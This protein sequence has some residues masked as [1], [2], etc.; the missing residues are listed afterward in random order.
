MDDEIQTIR[1]DDLVD[2][3]FVLR[4]VDQTGVEYVEL[5]DSLKKRGFLNSICVRPCKRWLG[6]WEIVDGRWRVTAAR[7]VRILTVPCIVKYGLTDKDVLAMQVIANAARPKTAPSAYARQIRRLLSD[8][9]TMTQAEL[10][11]L[12][13]KSTVWVRKM[14]GMARLART[15]VY[16]KAIDRGE[17]SM[18]AAYC[19]SRLPRSLWAQYF[20]DACVMPVREFKAL[21]MTALRQ[22]RASVYSGRLDA[23]HNSIGTP[24]PYLRALFDV[25]QEIRDSGVGPL[26]IASHGHTTAIEGWKAALEWA[27][28]LDPD[29]VERQRRRVLKRLKKRR[30]TRLQSR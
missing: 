23:K 30:V 27:A 13:N 29:S 17:L 9:E 1:V 24:Q 28:H 3:P 21:I 18:G 10:C 20:S 6:K 2:P 16:R 12:L 19:L 15:V 5:R 25:V 22:Y 14:L 8:E 26:L 4:E 11:Q 7:E